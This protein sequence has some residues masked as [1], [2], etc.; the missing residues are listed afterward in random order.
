MPVKARLTS[1]NTYRTSPKTVRDLPEW[2]NDREKPK[3]GAVQKLWCQ[4]T[5]V[6]LFAGILGLIALIFLKSA[7]S[8]NSDG[9]PRD[10]VV[11]GKRTYYQHVPMEYRRRFYVDDDNKFCHSSL[12]K[13]R[14]EKGQ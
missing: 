4:E 2:K 8:H 6:R 3:Y 1:T 10:L 12:S 9:P 11:V 5:R 14:M 13:Q 7:L